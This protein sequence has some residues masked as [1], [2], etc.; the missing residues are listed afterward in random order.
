[1]GSDDHP[2]LKVAIRGVLSEAAWQRC[3]VRF[4]ALDFMPDK[5]SDDS[6][7]KLRRFYDRRG[8]AMV[9]RDLA[10]RLAKWQ[11]KFRSCALGW[12][13]YRGK[14]TFYRLP[15]A[16]DK[17]MESTSMLER[18]NQ[19]ITRCTLLMR[20][21]PSAGRCVRLVPALATHENWLKRD[22]LSEF[23]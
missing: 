1:M 11:G 14:A 12:K 10:A 13:T 2:S 19:D 4:N 16:A 21:S 7:R 23:E 5:M 3:Y 17:H 6:L 18:L 20:I 22:A 8:L 9:R 15:L